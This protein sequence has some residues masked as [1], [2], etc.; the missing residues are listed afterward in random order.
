MN[1]P[2]ID[3]DLLLRDGG[4]AVQLTEPLPAG[5]WLI[6]DVKQNLLIVEF[7]GFI[8]AMAMPF[9]TAGQVRI[10]LVRL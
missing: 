2:S 1:A 4:G 10:P 3:L 6:Y 9:C 8:R 7:E 5:A